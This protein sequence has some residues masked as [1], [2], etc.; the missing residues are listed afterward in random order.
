[1]EKTVQKDAAQCSAKIPL[2]GQV[3]CSKQLLEVR[4]VNQDQDHFSHMQLFIFRGEEGRVCDVSICSR[5]LLI[6]LLL[7]AELDHS[8][9]KHPL[10]SV[11]P[12]QGLSQ[13]LTFFK[14]AGGLDL[15]RKIEVELVH[16][17]Y[18][19]TEITDGEEH[20]DAHGDRS[21]NYSALSPVPF[22]ILVGKFSLVAENSAHKRIDSK[23]PG[24]IFYGI[25]L[26]QRINR[27]DPC[28]L[29]R[30]DPCRDQN[31]CD[32]KNYNSENDPRRADD[33]YASPHSLRS[34]DNIR[35]KNPAAENGQCYFGAN[36]PHEKTQRNADAAKDKTFRIDGKTLLSAGRSNTCQH[37]E[38]THFLC[39]RH[40]ERIHDQNDR[41]RNDDCE[42]DRHQHEQRAI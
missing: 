28:R 13:L 32:G 22:D 39:E 23:F 42:R 20:D 25:G 26:A 36:Q 31:C 24:L 8:S 11:H 10:H 6:R 30:R 21:C 38:I 34:L 12:G 27:H 14:R 16:P 1:M 15:E 17:L 33:G 18:S 7:E 35:L 2:F 41:G 19:I 40:A 29:P 37:A 4:V 3:I 9:G 5:I